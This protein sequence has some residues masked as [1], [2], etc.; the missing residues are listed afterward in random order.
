MRM[1]KFVQ[2][3]LRKSKVINQ[4]LRFSVTNCNP[5]LI[6]N[7]VGSLSSL[8]SWGKDILDAQDYKGCKDS[9]E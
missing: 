7:K 6:L 9:I 2:S 3:C 4:C 5:I 1:E 8:F